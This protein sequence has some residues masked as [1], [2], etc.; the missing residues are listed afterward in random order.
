MTPSYDAA[1]SSTW[2]QWASQQ[3]RKSRNRGEKAPAKLATSNM[4]AALADDDEGGDEDYSVAADC[5]VASPADPP[6]LDT[7]DDI[8]DDD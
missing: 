8:Y 1:K 2:Q 3:Q 4:F 6:A 7:G 5:E